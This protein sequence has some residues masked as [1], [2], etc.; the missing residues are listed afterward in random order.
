M[1]N[2]PQI[3][4]IC[5]EKGFHYRKDV[6]L[7]EYTSFKIGG[8]AALFLEPSSAEELCQMVKELSSLGEIF[9][10]GDNRLNSCDSRYQEYGGSHLKDK[11]YKATDVYGVVPEWA[12]E[13]QEILAKIF[14]R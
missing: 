5:A 9:F 10:L 7:K 13:H 14:F 1:K 12:L 3:E 8:T 6:S 2:I 4:A 11:L